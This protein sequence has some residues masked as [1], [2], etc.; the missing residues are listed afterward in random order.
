M[1]EPE[2]PQTPAGEMDN[3]QL[4]MGELRALSLGDI[5]DQ[6]ALSGSDNFVLQANAAEKGADIQPVGVI[7]TWGASGQ[8]YI[9]AALAR[10][11]KEALKQ[12]RAER[13]AGKKLNA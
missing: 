5:L 1:Q 8:K 12:F 6:L 7:V 11:R 10:M 4:T 3:S 9:E 13:A 2:Q